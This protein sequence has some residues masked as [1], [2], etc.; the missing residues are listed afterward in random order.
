MKEVALMV[1]WEYGIV[2]LALSNQITSNV[3]L[4]PARQFKAIAACP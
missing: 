1:S 4:S 3:I 2:F